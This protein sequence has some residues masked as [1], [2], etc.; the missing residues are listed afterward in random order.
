MRQRVTEHFRITE[1]TMIHACVQ[2]LKDA[3]GGGKVHVRDPHPDDLLVGVGDVHTSAAG[4]YAEALGI[5]AVDDPVKVPAHL[6]RLLLKC[7]VPSA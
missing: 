4:F 6:F 2:R 3:V 5:S 1:N 7:D